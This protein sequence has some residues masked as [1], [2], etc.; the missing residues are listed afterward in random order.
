MIN[1]P[2]QNENSRKIRVIYAD[3]EKECHD[4]MGHFLKRTFPNN[5]VHL[6]SAKNG[7]DLLNHLSSEEWDFC[8]SDYHMPEMT[9]FEAV[10][11]YRQAKPNKNIPTLFVTGEGV[12]ELHQREG[13]LERTCVLKKPFSIAQFKEAV[14]SLLPEYAPH[15][16]AKSL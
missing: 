12:E 3:D 10:A 15:E 2:K 16:S 8:I 1:D 13:M 11:A 4:L 6:I 7:R 5:D 14:Y 9:G